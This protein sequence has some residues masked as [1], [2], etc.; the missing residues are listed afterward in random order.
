MS[1][2]ASAHTLAPARADATRLRGVLGAAAPTSMLPPASQPRAEEMRDAASEE[3]QSRKFFEQAIEMFTLKVEYA[4]AVQPAAG[5]PEE[6][7]Q[8][9]SRYNEAMFELAALEEDANEN[10]GDLPVLETLEDAKAVVMYQLP[11]VA[12]EVVRDA[13]LSWPL[14]R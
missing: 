12:Q 4:Y 6:A 2:R 13:T 9:E 8:R 11:A 5:S 3:I 14:R 10:P 1:V 7:A